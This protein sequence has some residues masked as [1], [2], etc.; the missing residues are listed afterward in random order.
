MLFVLIMVGVFECITI[1]SL[2]K[3]AVSGIFSKGY[4]VFRESRRVKLDT[5]DGG[6]KK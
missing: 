6:N 1:C 4:T 5:N 3:H 2:A